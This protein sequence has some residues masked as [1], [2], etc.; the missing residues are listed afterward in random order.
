MS[1][2]DAIVAQA[3]LWVGYEEGAANANV[4]SA[5]LGEAGRP[6][7]QDFILFI[8]AAA[9]FRQPIETGGVVAIGT[10]A[11]QKGIFIKSTRATAGCQILFDFSLGDGKQPA[12]PMKTHTGI[13]LGDGLSI[14][15]NTDVP[16]WVHQKKVTLG[17]ADIWGAINW[18]AYWATRRVPFSQATARFPHYPVL[19][20]N[21][22]V[23]DRVFGLQRALNDVLGI[24]LDVDG[25]F[26]TDTADAC[27]QF[28]RASRIPVTGVADQ[29]TWACLDI[30]LD[31][32]TK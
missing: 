18:P 3:K 31:K 32:L 10:Y 8:S 28:Q 26:G 6:W 5:G 25:Q 29:Q 4:F 27:K 16:G 24:K 20:Q 7:C 2:S 15:G 11:Q 14:Q 19:G 23:D 13:Y 1:Y 17:A 12:D 9:G 30:S 21:G 22:K